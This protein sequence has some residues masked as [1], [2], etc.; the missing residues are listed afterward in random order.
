MNINW[1]I[2]YKSMDLQNSFK[3]GKKVIGD[4]YPIYLIGDVGL[5]NGGDIERSFKLIDELAKLGVDAVKFQMIKPEELLGDKNI[6]YTFPTLKNGNI[7]QNMYEMFSELNYSDEDWF[8]IA[9]YTFSKKL[10]FICTSHVMSAVDTLEKCD[11]NIHKICTW[12]VTHKRLIEKIGNTKKP[13][14]LDTGASSTE[15]LDELIGWYKEKGGNHVIILHDFHTKNFNEMNFK[16]IPFMKKRYN[17]PV[18][19]TPQGR[20][21]DLDYLSI[22]IGV[23]I[24]E[25]RLT[26][27]RS[28][29]KNGHWKSLEPKEFKDWII[30]VK[31][32][33]KSLGTYKVTPT[34]DDIS[35]SSWGFKSL[36]SNKKIN[37]GELI[38]ENMLKAARPGTGI[39]P[40]KID[41]IIGKK[42]IIDINKDQII[43]WD[44]LD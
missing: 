21:S 11:V 6:N 13:F 42:A 3:I 10:E 12:S 30:N 39:S 26:L 23:N 35:I 19:F 2:A 24:L 22:G 17:V 8:K 4:N 31:N 16:A 40:S 34:S 41:E 33:E 44:Y 29:P 36:F 7:T 27:D 32:L 20:E 37:K 1:Q 38:S 28:I 18:G 25:K 15:E 14:M 9:K 5:T 43:K